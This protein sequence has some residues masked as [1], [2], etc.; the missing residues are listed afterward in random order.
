MDNEELQ[1]LNSEIEKRLQD[2]RNLEKFA[3]ADEQLIDKR[4]A[5]HIELFLKEI[6]NNSLISVT[7]APFSL[8]ILQTNLQIHTGLLI[9]SFI[10]FMINALIL[11]IGYWYYNNEFFRS[12]ASQKLENLIMGTSA[13][14]INDASKDNKKRLNSLFDFFQSQSKLETKRKLEPYTHINTVD[15]IRFIGIAILSSAILFLIA[16]IVLPQLKITSW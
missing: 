3:Q 8:L 15:K 14:Q 4:M 7:A 13:M 2:F 1:K 6:R 16:S 10:L 9:G 12:T 11:N 5:E